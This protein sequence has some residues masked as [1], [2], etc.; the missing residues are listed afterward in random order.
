MVLQ[1][2]ETS[3]LSN[4]HTQSLIK[5]PYKIMDLVIPH[6]TLIILFPLSRGSR[7]LTPTSLYARATGSVKD[8]LFSHFI[9]KS[10][11]FQKQ[12]SLITSKL[13]DCIRCSVLCAGFRVLQG[14]PMYTSIFFSKTEISIIES[15]IL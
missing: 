12:N 1:D 13:Y 9:I 2:F 6:T 15:K 14:Y 5:N 4:F 8:G 10:N 3:S 11:K 7:L